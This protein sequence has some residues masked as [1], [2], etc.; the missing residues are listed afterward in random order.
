MGRGHTCSTLSQQELHGNLVYALPIAH[1]QSVH[2]AKGGRCA[3]SPLSRA[4]GPA[5]QDCNETWCQ[6]QGAL[7]TP[8]PACPC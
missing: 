6:C 7:P 8:T 1:Q 4:A 2:S 3:A 5:V